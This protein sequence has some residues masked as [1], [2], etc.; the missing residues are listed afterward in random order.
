MKNQ[1]EGR[2]VRLA[3]QDFLQVYIPEPL[4]DMDKWG[5]ASLQ[6]VFVLLWVLAAW[7]TMRCRRFRN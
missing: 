2:G 4:R 6:A 7:V 1:F 5:L 3:G